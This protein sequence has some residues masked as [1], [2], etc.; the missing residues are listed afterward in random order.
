MYSLIQEILFWVLCSWEPPFSWSHDSMS[1]N[2][3]NNNSHGFLPTSSLIPPTEKKGSI[4]IVDFGR[5]CLWTK[6]GATC[7]MH[8]KANLLTPGCGEGKYS[9]YCKENKPLM[10]KR[11]KLPNDFEGRVFKD[12]VR[13]RVTGYVIS[14]YSILWLVDGEVTCWCFGESHSPTLWFQPT[15]RYPCW[16]SACS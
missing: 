4:T 11:P 6:H 2:F 8:S 10:L 13:E 16:W 9:V 12:S 7:L 15:M 3:C 14:L 1:K 5:K